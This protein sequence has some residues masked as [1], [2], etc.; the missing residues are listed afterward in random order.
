MKRLF[1]GI[2]FIIITSSMKNIS[3]VI[4]FESDYFCCE[5]GG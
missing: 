5:V 2:K 1:T 3:A 4:S